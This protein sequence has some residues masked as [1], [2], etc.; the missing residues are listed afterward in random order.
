MSGAATVFALC[1]QLNCAPIGFE[2]SIMQDINK[3]AVVV[4]M[5]NLDLEGGN[6]FR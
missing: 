4:T 3:S 6:D 5:R 2:E 1:V